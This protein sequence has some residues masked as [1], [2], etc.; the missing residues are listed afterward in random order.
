MKHLIDCL[1]FSL[2][3]QSAEMETQSAEAVELPQSAGAVELPKYV[4]TGRVHTGSESSH[5]YMKPEGS[6]SEQLVLF[7]EEAMR[8]LKDYITKN[9]IPNDVPDEPL[10]ASSSDD[11]D[12]VKSKKTKLT[13]F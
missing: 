4:V 1:F 6:L 8:V 3:V 12:E 7:K 9:N 2:A 5:I 13:S 10:E 11:D